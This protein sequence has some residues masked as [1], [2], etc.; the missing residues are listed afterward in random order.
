MSL[1][2]TVLT[3]LASW[4]LGEGGGDE[5]DVSLM[6]TLARVLNSLERNRDFWAAQ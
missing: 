5:V 3:C 1:R 2:R 4:S 6:A